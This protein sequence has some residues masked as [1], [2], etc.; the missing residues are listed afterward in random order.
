MSSFSFTGNPILKALNLSAS[1]LPGI[2]KV[3]AVYF[4]PDDSTVKAKSFL[5]KLNAE[6]ICDDLVI[7]DYEVQ[8]DKMRKSIS[9]FEWL[10][11]DDIPFEERQKKKAAQM[12]VF[13]ELENI[14]LSIG[15]LNEYD[16][17]YD[18][19]LI[20]F[21][22]DLSNFGVSESS[23]LLTPDHK[24]IIGTLLYNSYKTFIEH[25]KADTT[26]LQSFNENT[27]SLIKK[28]SQTKEDLDRSKFNYGHS[29]A[30][31]CRL[32][33]K[34]LSDAHPHFN[35]LLTDD[36]I[37]KIKTYQGDITELKGIIQKATEYV[38]NLY[39]DN[40]VS[41]IYITEDYLNFD[42]HVPHKISKPQE[43]QLYDRYSKTIMLL[44][45]LE[46]AAREVLAKNLDLTSANVGSA[47]SVPI[48][49]PAISDAVKKH[50]NKIIYL[51]NKYPDRWNLIRK[52]FR[53]VRNIISSRPDVIEKSA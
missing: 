44:D 14:I 29:L 40:A 46:T 32:Y 26:V 27:K 33:V 17:K 1:F 38:G 51:L 3:V 25:S 21:N 50:R 23:K 2:E 41:D 35:F 28:L 53:P 10:R 5:N 24:N 36:A 6:S 30:D 31:L 42:L 47:C 11:K 37:A 13:H 22:Q 48:T 43:I 18:L 20:Y 12:N 34:E 45:K 16:S 49:A 8:I 9:Y 39:F 19:F 15:F 7:D 52:D 4:S